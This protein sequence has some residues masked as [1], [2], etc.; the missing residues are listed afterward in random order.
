MTKGRRWKGDLNKPF[1][2]ATVVRPHGFAVPSKDDP[3]A[4]QKIAAENALMWSLM[5]ASVRDEETRKLALLSSEYGIPAEDFRSLALALAR[6][7]VPGFRPEPRKRVGRVRF[8]D[9]TRLSELFND[10][11]AIKATAQIT[12][13]EALSRLARKKKW[14]PPQSHRGDLRGWLETLESRLQE[15]KHLRQR[16]DEALKLLQEIVREHSGKA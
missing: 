14:A 1:R 16:A 11:A 7:F 15:E 10:V 9:D 5:D 13:R 8:W 3:E 12:D 4:E 6:E 2:P